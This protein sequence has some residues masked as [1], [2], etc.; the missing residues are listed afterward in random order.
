MSLEGSSPAR[1]AQ[2]FGPVASVVS[3]GIGTLVVV[4]AWL[5]LF[6]PLRRAGPLAGPEP[7]P[8]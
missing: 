7:R 1:V 2:I 3:G 4:A 6:P 8:R 5:M